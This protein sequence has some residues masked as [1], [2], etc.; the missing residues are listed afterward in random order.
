MEYIHL[1]GAEQVQSAGNTMRS[2][3]D[4]M[5][6]AASNIDGA[7]YRHQQF[8]EDWLQRLAEVMEQRV[9]VEVMPPAP[10]PD[11]IDPEAESP[12]PQIPICVKSGVCSL[13]DGHDG[14]CNDDYMPF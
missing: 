5:E 3:A 7:L 2:A 12:A 10:Y 6:R 13:H 8:L 14:P 4:T 9:T 1:M 11:I